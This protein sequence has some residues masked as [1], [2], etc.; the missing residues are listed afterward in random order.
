M[1]ANAIRQLDEQYALTSRQKTV[2]FLGSIN[3]TL[4]FFVQFLIAYVLV[5]LARPWHLT[6]GKSAVIFV[7]SGTGSIIGSFLWGHVAD[8]FGRRPALAGFIAAYSLSSLALAFTPSGN[9]IY[10]AIFCGG[11]GLGV[12]GY[13]VNVA[14][15]QEFTPSQKRGWASGIISVS[16]PGGVLLSAV[17]TAFLAPLIGWRGIFAVGAL[18]AFFAIVLLAYI[19]ESPR[20]A[21]KR[22]RLDVARKSAAWALK[23]PEEELVLEQVD[24]PHTAA[25]KWTEIFAFRRSVLISLLINLGVIAGIYGMLLW[26]PTLLVMIQRISVKTASE[27]MMAIAVSGMLAR[28]LFSYLSEMI[29][30]RPSGVI[31]AFGSAI[32]LAITGWVGRGGSGL[33]SFFW[34]FLLA[35]F[36]LADG[37]FAISAPYTTEI[38]PSRLR[39]SGGGFGYGAGGFGKI[40]G[41][42]GLALIIGSSNY[43][44]PGVTVA[45]IE[46]AFLYLALWFVLA[47]LTYIFA[48]FETKGRSLDEIDQMISRR[49]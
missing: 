43:I 42:L 18:P 1:N 30:R 29:G 38:W 27:I 25:P 8:R 17:C 24:E 5:I 9:W 14:L 47:G 16:A 15:I 12:G 37:G 39:A 21:L 44:K 13:T 2:I 32:L 35:T 33:S 23:T 22:G 45:S 3:G 6:Y 48:G 11:V 28:I 46:P 41:P 7:A 26:S 10:L 40:L 4:E 19:P 36:F 34:L 20:W 31:S 49:A